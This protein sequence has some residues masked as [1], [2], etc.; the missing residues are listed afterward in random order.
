ML[1][2]TQQHVGGCVYAFPYE[3]SLPGAFRMTVKLI[4]S[5]YSA[6]DEVLH[7]DEALLRL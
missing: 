6:V 4:R 5:N 7:A 2:I 3:V 1:A